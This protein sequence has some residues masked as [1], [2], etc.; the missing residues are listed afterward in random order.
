MQTM[1]WTDERLEER[2]NGIDLRFDAVGQRFDGVDRRFDE[3][4]RR[5]AEMDHKS[6][7]RF[8]EVD[9]RF[10]ETDRRLDGIEAAMKELHS[11]L[12][13][14]GAGIIVSLFGVIAAILAKGA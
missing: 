14:V 1:A 11:L 8:D 10:G 6:D 4:N 13:R 9:R 2:F 3:T 5:L 12:H 7:W